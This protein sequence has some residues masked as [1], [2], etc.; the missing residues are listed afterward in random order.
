[1][2]HDDSWMHPTED[3]VNCSATSCTKRPTEYA[4]LLFR[5]HAYVFPLVKPETRTL[6]WPPEIHGDQPISRAPSRAPQAR[7]AASFQC[8]ALFPFAHD[9]MTTHRVPRY[10]GEATLADGRKTFT[11]RIVGKD[12]VST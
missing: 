9:I 1:M 5:V 3:H 10:T 11:F 8:T 4:D 7:I 12:N 2:C 6:V